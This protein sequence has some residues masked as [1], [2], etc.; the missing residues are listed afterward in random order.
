MMWQSMVVEGTDYNYERL[1]RP[2]QQP[3]TIVQHSS[4]ASSS[5]QQ[6]APKN[7][8]AMEMAIE[9]KQLL[10]SKQVSKEGA[11]EPNTNRIS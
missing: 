5:H 10:S 8:L 9:Q 11:P 2:W 4:L 3:D 7:L 6:K 1:K